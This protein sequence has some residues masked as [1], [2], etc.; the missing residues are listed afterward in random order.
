[1]KIIIDPILKQ[2]IVH[3][4]LLVKDYDEAIAFYVGK[5]QFTLV[6][7]TRLSDVKRWVL[8]QPP[9]STG[10]CLL[11]AKTANERQELAIGNQSGGRVFLFLNTDDF[12]RD[13]CRMIADGVSFI[14]EPIVESYGTVAVFKDL[15]GNLWDLIQ[16]KS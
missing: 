4:T 15:Y 5:L 7:D 11:L 8:V 14:R 16:T 3:I 2:D 9:G 13:Y 12:D 1:L 10:C 6:E